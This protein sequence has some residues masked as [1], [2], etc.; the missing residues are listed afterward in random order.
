MAFDSTGGIYPSQWQLALSGELEAYLA[1]AEE[2]VLRAARNALQTVASDGKER[3]RGMVVKAGLGREGAGEGRGS[4][5]SLA[6]AVRFEIYPK[7]GLARDPA[8]F[9]YIQPSATKIYESFEE[10]ARITGNGGKWLTIPIPG[11]PASREVFGDKPRGTT[12]LQRLKDKGIEIA[13]VPGRNGRP[14]ML[15]ANNVR[16]GQLKTGR[17]RVSKAKLT[18]TGGYAAGVQSVPLFW[19]VPAAQMPQK[20]SLKREFMRIAERFVDVFAAEFARQLTRVEQSA[21]AA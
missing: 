19:L 4:G 17:T 20:L 16:V 9:L 7:R 1:K 8:A 13:F 5:R 11:S 18:K 6:S 10:G 21:E 3:L 2:G 14:A 12:I 15:V